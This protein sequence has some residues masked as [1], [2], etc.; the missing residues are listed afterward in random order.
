MTSNTYSN[1]EV[2]ENK[3]GSYEFFTKE[4][5]QICVHHNIAIPADHEVQNISFEDLSKLGS[6]TI[7]DKNF[8]TWLLSHSP[9]LKARPVELIM[10][11]EGI[12]K[13]WDELVRQ[14]E[15]LKVK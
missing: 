8:L 6:L 9:F 10:S 11:K 3:Q 13:V 15:A 14:S 2:E 7:G 12:K 1:S 5:R 4:E